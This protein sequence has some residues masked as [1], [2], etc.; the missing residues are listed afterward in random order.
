MKEHWYS[1]SLCP[2][3]L[4]P[5]VYKVVLML[6]ASDTHNMLLLHVTA[7]DGQAM[8]GSQCQPALPQDSWLPADRH[9]QAS[10]APAGQGSG[11][12]QRP[13]SRSRGIDA[14]GRWQHGSGVA[15]KSA[16][17]TGTAQVSVNWVV[18][19]LETLGLGSLCMHECRSVWECIHY[20]G[21]GVHTLL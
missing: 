11:W 4:I 3:V 20:E 12:Q 8:H 6:S 9:H 14:Q 17:G 16:G 21:L 10:S 18:Q 2:S 15:G 19:G 1:L 5:G 7:G 13:H